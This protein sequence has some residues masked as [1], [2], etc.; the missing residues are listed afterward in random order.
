MEKRRE[1]KRREEKRREEKRREEKR[2]E[3][4]RREEKRRE[5]KGRLDTMDM[6]FED[7]DVDVEITLCSGPRLTD[8][9]SPDMTLPPFS[10]RNCTSVP[11]HVYTRRKRYRLL[12]CPMANIRTL[13][14]LRKIL[15]EVTVTSNQAQ[16]YEVH[17]VDRPP[18][19]EQG[20]QPP[21][22]NVDRVYCPKT[23][24]RTPLSGSFTSGKKI[25]VPESH[26]R[27]IRR[28]IQKYPVSPVK[29]IN[30]LDIHVT[31]TREAQKCVYNI[32]TNDIDYIK[33]RIRDAIH[34][35]TPDVLRRVWN[36]LEN[37]LDVY[38]VTNGSHINCTEQIYENRGL[39]GLS[40]VKLNYVL[41]NDARN[42]RGCISVA[43][44]SEFCPSEVPL[45][46]SK[47]T[48]MSLSHLST[49]KCHRWAGIICCF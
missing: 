6:E 34:S 1:E 29:Q 21:C 15:T 43:V 39:V 25:V 49:L 33:E 14:W 47:S 37:R 41:F 28:M 5:E 27:R 22:R 10:L 23:R 13:H 35:V 32:R 7:E 46:A 36:E 42:C 48:D 18:G 20:L 2:R 8:F 9:T 45:H 40:A 24:Q 31:S 4:K 19:H 38:R 12:T 17:R 30:Y 11:P 16:F 26:I 44:V 3:E